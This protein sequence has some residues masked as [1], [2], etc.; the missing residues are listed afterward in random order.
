MCNC[1]LNFQYPTPPVVPLL[2]LDLYA[3]NTGSDYINWPYF[4][5]WIMCVLGSQKPQP[6]STCLYVGSWFLIQFLYIISHQMRLML[7]TSYKIRVDRM[8]TIYHWSCHKIN[9]NTSSAK[10]LFDQ[11][12]NILYCTLFNF[13]CTKQDLRNMP[14]IISLLI[15]KCY[16]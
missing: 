11:Y 10:Q 7:W 8:L 2:K 6:D 5:I 14:I 3:N 13:S 16:S 15:T 1:S 4:K 9:K 12:N